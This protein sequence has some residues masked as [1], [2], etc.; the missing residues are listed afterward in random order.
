MAGRDISV[1]RGGKA[2]NSASQQIME[3]LFDILL[4]I[5]PA[6]RAAWVDPIVALRHE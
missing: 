2:D 3:F 4:G 6:I 1:E 5:Y